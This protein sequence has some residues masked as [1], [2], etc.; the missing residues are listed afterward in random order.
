MKRI[1]L[2]ATLVLSTY[3]TA[4]DNP[5]RVPELRQGD[6]LSGA[7]TAEAGM[8][9]STGWSEK[10]A[11][12]EAFEAEAYADPGS[13]EAD[14]SNIQGLLPDFVSVSWDEQ[15]F[16][17][18]TGATAF[19]NLRVTINTE[20]AFG[21]A[22]DEARVWGFDDDLLIARL[23]GERFDETGRVF[24][25]LE[26]DGYSL[27]GAAGAME[28]VF[29]VMEAQIG[30]EA[31]S[32]VDFGVNQFDMTVESTVTGPLTLRP[33][34]YVPLSE[35]TYAQLTDMLEIEPGELEEEGF[36][37]LQ[38]LRLAQQVIAVG[39]SVEIERGSARNMDMTMQIDSPEVSQ[40]VSYTLDFYGYEG[41][42]GYD[43]DGIYY[44]G[45]RQQQGMSFDGEA[46]EAEEVYPDGLDIDQL[47]T[48]D[49]MS[50]EGIRLDTLAGFLA[51][52][53]F[54]GLDQRDLISL[55]QSVV[56][57]YTYQMG[58]AEMFRVDEM[59]VTANE[60]EWLLPEEILVDMQ[61]VAVYPGQIGETVLTFVP[62]GEDEEIQAVR[63]D[64]EAGIDLL[65]EHGFSEIP[66]DIQTAMTWNKDSGETEFSFAAQSE[67][68]GERI[69]RL[70]ITLPP[71]DPI[72][73]AAEEG[74]LDS[75]FEDLFETHFTFN[76]ARLYESDD[77]GYDKLFGYLHALGQQ[78]ESEGW[79]ATLA[80]MPP[81]DLRQFIAVMTRS[82]KGRVQ[83]QFPQ[84]VDWI[85]AVA[86][87]FETS[88]GSLD[89]RLDPPSPLTPDR[90]EELARA[91]D[92]DAWVEQFGI[93]VTHTSE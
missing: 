14:L 28:A 66:A 83:D 56:T 46:L 30:E 68:F 88:G 13:S 24:D 31:S 57:N 55:G 75:A 42:S 72:A 34:E 29:D 89:I 38:A 78:H 45:M 51:R 18:T 41:L 36:D 77:G 27:F 43:I 84:A 69:A 67:G 64:I 40:T 71:Y 73:A 86:A 32:E 23:N 79:G 63:A 76:G 25:R 52:S 7:E 5:P 54:P 80:G 16:D 1:S 6:G 19:D 61:G 2:G 17:E 53:E 10:F 26:A 3:L 70:G 48:A 87:Y 58:G 47:L 93:S 90:I 15:S 12:F 11:A 44:E 81:E 85:E 33:F 74:E 21:V 62:S 65:D 82:A 92:M 59:S 4:C 9:G 35:E 8:S 50:Y 49:Y 20:P 39:R 37:G 91:N 60:F 22:M